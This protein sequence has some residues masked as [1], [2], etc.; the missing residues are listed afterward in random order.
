[1]SY[2]S[3]KRFAVLG[4]GHGGQAMACHLAIMGFDVAL[5]NR[6][7]HRIEPIKMRGGIELTGEVTGFGVPR[8]VT[9][10]PAEAIEEADVVMVVVPASAHQWMAQTFAPHF[11]DGQVI[12]LNPGRTG[13]AMEFRKVLRDARCKAQVIV[14]EAQTFIYAS[15]SMGPAQSRIFRIKNTVPVAAL[16]ASDT[17]ALL[18]AIN[19]AYPQFVPAPSVLN[20]SLDNMGAVFHPT[21]TL[22]N[23]GWIEA[24]AGE[25]EFY[26]EGVTTSV[27]KVLEEVD[28]ERVAV[29]RALGVRAVTALEWLE[30]AYAA[31]GETLYDAMHNNEGY[32]GIK[33]PPTI[34]NRYLF[35]DIPASLVPIAS[36]GNMV[37]VPTP[38]ISALVQIGCLVHQTDYWKEGRTVEKLGLAGMSIDEIRE[39]VFHGR[40]EMG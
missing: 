32:E 19:E 14:G 13:G 23:T 9:T 15:R 21:I 38:T 8:V 4:A 36:I 1:M 16:P 3:R 34:R 33:A 24:R 6:G 39:F 20:T 5:F 11:K 18:A 30:M 17:P 7:H 12:L 31:V 2:E 37:G 40:A 27:A 25:F 26:F 10:D 35:E 29:A 28:A 22:L